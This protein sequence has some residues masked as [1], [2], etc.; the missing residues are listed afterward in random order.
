MACFVFGIS[1]V[2]GLLEEIGYMARISFVFDNAM[3]KFGLHGKA[4]MPFLTSFACNMGGVS[5]TR[6]IDSWGQRVTAMA[7]LWLIPCSATWGVVAFVS[8]LFFGHWSLLVLLS[9]FAV[10]AAH[11]FITSRI[12][13]R[14]LIG[15]GER[16]GFIMELPP[17][18]MPRWRNLL[19]FVMSR[20]GDV[21]SRG[22]RVVLAVAVLFW[23]LSH[24][25][26]GTVSGSLLQRMGMF[27]EPLTMWFG[28]RW[29]MFVAFLVSAMGKE[30]S[31]GVLASIFE[32]TECD[33]WTLLSASPAASSTAELASALVATISRPEALAFLYAFFF[34]IP[35]LMTVATTY[36]E[37]RSLRWT[38][39]MVAYYF[40]IALLLSAVAYRVGKLFL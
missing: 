36:V 25:G 19:S 22:L 37:S 2:F 14:A 38:L 24:T 17:Y 5:G 27:I 7:M 1:F 35:C 16:S 18:H 29:Q 13:G 20:I 6:V 30:A 40:S 32:T 15:E 8:A 9:L 28:L 34:G 4:I 26:N 31:L 21:L 3:A 23:M 12:F 39:R 11:F 10:A 33:S